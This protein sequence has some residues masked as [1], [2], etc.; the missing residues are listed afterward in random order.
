MCCDVSKKQMALGTAGK[1][2]EDKNDVKRIYYGRNVLTYRKM[3][4]MI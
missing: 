4:V 1:D 2:S 3:Y